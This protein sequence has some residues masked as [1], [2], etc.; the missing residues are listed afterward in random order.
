MAISDTSQNEILKC[1]SAQR[2]LWGRLMER[3]GVRRGKGVVRGS[4][5]VGRWDASGRP[6]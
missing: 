1:R 4:R 5:T 6:A 3:A 2:R